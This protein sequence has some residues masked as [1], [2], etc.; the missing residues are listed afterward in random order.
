MPRVRR[1]LVDAHTDG[2]TLGFLG[3]PCVNVVELN[4]ELDSKYPFRG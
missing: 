4:I 3:E 1:A 2:R